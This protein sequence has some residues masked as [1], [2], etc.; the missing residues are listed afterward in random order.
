VEILNNI[1]ESLQ[2]G[3]HHTVAEL[4]RQ[5]IDSGL[6]AAEIGADGYS[7]NAGSAVGLVKHL[8]GTA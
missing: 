1:S 7:Y 5:A 6:S 2:R 4:T 3:D 8:L